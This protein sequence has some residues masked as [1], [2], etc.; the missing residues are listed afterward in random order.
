MLQQQYMYY[1]NV[2]QQRELYAGLTRTAYLHVDG[3]CS[4]SASTSHNIMIDCDVHST[5]HHRS[6]NVHTSQCRK[7][8]SHVLFCLVLVQAVLITA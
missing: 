6:L 7:L 8:R 1:L 5:V 4:S 2:V 3:M